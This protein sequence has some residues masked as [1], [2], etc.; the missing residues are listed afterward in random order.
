MG[1][2]GK[3]EEKTRVKNKSKTEE[4]KRK[5]TDIRIIRLMPSQ[6]IKG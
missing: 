5:C 3:K 2:K 4:K 6:Q 1:V